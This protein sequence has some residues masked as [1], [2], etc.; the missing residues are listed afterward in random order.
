MNT[1]TEKMT[2]IIDN[3]TDF[4][5]DSWKSNES[6]FFQNLEKIYLKLSGNTKIEISES[7]LAQF[8]SELIDYANQGLFL[9]QEFLNT[10]CI[11]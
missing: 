7:Q 6:F 4:L 3:L 1:F 8:N 9:F 11:H 2:P 5:L 10:Q